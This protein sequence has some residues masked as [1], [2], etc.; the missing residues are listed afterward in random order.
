[1]YVDAEAA[2]RARPLVRGRGEPEPWTSFDGR[3]LARIV[4]SHAV[5]AERRLSASR[6][7]VEHLDHAR[8]SDGLAAL[9]I[10]GP[11]EIR[12]GTMTPGRRVDVVFVEPELVP[13]TE[14]AA[15]RWV[16]IDIE[17]D[18]AGGV[19]AVSLAGGG[20]SEVL[21]VASSPV[22]GATCVADERALLAAFCERLRA[23]DPD[24]ITGWNVVEFDLQVLAQRCAAHG[25]A[26]DFGRVP[27]TTEVQ[28]RKSGR[29]AVEI[30][31]RVVVDA[32]RLV[33]AS[34]ERVDDQSLDGAA[35][36]LLGDGHGKT[37][38]QR[39]SA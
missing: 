13:S 1:V 20:P 35:Q 2:E 30:A 9:G 34:G 14:V 37:V 4:V 29:L 11:V 23:R 15:V 26:L 21:F 32:M 24:V 33:R 3:P 7:R 27:G 12:G 17:T 6:L 16:A 10:R 38:A 19:V 31:G 18:R 28:T 36:A 8:A 22:A 25:I 39:G 5:D